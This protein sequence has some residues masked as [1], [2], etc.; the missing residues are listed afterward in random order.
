[1][2]DIVSR[3]N[4]LPHCYTLQSCYGH[5][6]YGSQEDP[7]DLNPLPVTESTG[8]VEYRIAYIALCVENCHAGRR[9]LQLLRDLVLLEPDTIQFGSADWFWQRRVNSYAL[10]VEPGRFKHQDRAVLGYQEALHVEKVRNHLFARLKELLSKTA[11]S[12]TG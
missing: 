5:F 1:V 3:L 6:V 8:R 2:V 10:Q 9:L 7:H 12:P 11:P 4:R